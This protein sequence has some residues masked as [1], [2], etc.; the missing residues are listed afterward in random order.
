MA[1]LRRLHTES[2]LFQLLFPW[3]RGHCPSLHESNLAA[4]A[5]FPRAVLIF[6]PAALVCIC[7]RVKVSA[8]DGRV[9]G[10]NGRLTPGFRRKANRNQQE[11]LKRKKQKKVQRFKEMEEVR[12]QEKSKW[13]QFNS[14]VR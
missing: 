13:Q 14:K 7:V 5:K 3:Q 2:G 9:A 8:R 11:Y 6:G 4:N 12:E 1:A 10:F